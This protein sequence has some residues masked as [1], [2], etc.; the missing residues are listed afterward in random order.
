MKKFS[1]FLL[2]IILFF[3]SS[4]VFA[5][6]S[7]FNKTWTESYDTVRN[8]NVVSDVLEVEDGLLTIG[9]KNNIVFITLLTPDGILVKNVTISPEINGRGLRLFA[10][11]NGYIGF[12]ATADGMYKILI[13]SDYEVTRTELYNTDELFYYNKVYAVKI[14]KE[15]Y[16]FTGYTY[17]QY[18]IKY[19]FE[20]QYFSDVLYEDLSNKV[21]KVLDGYFN[22]M[23]Y[24]YCKR[25]LIDDSYNTDNTTVIDPDDETTEDAYCSEFEA[26]FD[27]GYI[28]SLYDSNKDV[29]KL[30]YY[31]DDEVWAK[32]VNDTVYV[33]GSQV[34]D[35]FVFS[36]VKKEGNNYVDYIEIIDDKGTVVESNAFGDFIITE[37]IPLNDDFIASGYKTYCKKSGKQPKTSIIKKS[38]RKFIDLSSHSGCDDTLYLAL[39]EYNHLIETKTDGNGTIT[40]NKIRTSKGTEVEFTIEPKKGY[41]LGVVKVTDENGNVLTFTDYKFIMPDA[42]VLIEATFEKEPLNPLTATGLSLGILAIAG[43]SGYYAIKQRKKLK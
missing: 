28:F 24:D 22:M 34:N 40:A 8:N 9:T 25:L 16:F 35:N 10:V 30:V 3:C 37:V 31:K 4:I 20:D 42:N 26:T 1:Y 6:E 13:N 27:G 19:D 33:A 17:D 43:A 29:G 39:F 18:L 23:T 11:E 38:V 21:T 14:D 2:I 36:V 15:L 7:L 41:V 5:E 12:A 32:T